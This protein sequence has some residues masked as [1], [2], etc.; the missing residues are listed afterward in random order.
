MIILYCGAV[1]YNVI[2]VYRCLNVSFPLMLIVLLFC[3]DV[4]STSCRYVY[5]VEVLCIR[6]LI[7]SSVLLDLY[8]GHNQLLLESCGEDLR[9]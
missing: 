3:E 4:L 5:L 8:A 9:E 7:L 2:C 1:G 6:V